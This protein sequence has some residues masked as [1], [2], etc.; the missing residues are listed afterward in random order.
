MKLYVHVTDN[1]GKLLGHFP[2]LPEDR[3]S[4]ELLI[5]HNDEVFK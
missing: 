2:S 1:D 4:N 5:W 3:P